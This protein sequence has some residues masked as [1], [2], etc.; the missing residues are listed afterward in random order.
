M[1]IPPGRATTELTPV[2]A[3]HN[4]GGGELGLR[5]NPEGGSGGGGHGLSNDTKRCLV[6][7][8]IVPPLGTEVSAS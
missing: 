2:S 7:F 4:G 1:Y 3:P 8:M 6:F 5:Q